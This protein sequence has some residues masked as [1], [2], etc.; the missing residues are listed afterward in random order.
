MFMYRLAGTYRQIGAEYGMLLRANRVPL[1]QLSQTRR[2]FFK[3]CEPHLREHAAELFDEVEGIAEGGGYDVARI[4]GIALAPSARPEC[5]VMAIA[6]QHTAS[7][8][9]MVGR[10]HDW[11]GAGYLAFCETRPQ[12]AIPSLGVNDLFVGRPDGIN[13]AG[14]AVAITAVEG[15]RDHPGIMFNLA[16]R[17]VL[18]RCHSTEEAV[19][20]LQRIRHARTINF[21][22]ADASGDIALVEAAPRK[23]HVTRPENGVA[24][25]TNHFQ[26]DEMAR[27]EYV[28]KRAPNSYPRYCT[29]REWF[30][31]RRGP[32]TVEDMQAIFRTPYSQGVC[33]LPRGHGRGIHTVWSWVAE[34]GTGELH[35]AA[36]SPCE[37]AY[38]AYGFSD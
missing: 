11:F 23:V 38:K 3:A 17:M 10:N 18:D 7:G 9:T 36:G 2:E 4:R 8:K 24:V 34:L 21:L 35:F 32:I 22:V 27:Y 12:G 1:P 20:F 6:G 16:S 14:V 28:R 33:V 13:A 31:A 15:G 26:S 25:V 37:T 19:Q 30:A 29:L 5:T